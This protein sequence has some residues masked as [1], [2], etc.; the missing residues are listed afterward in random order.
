MRRVLLMALVIFSGC[1]SQVQPS[2]F[3][4]SNAVMKEG[5][6]FKHEYFLPGAVLGSYSSVKIEPV[7]LH[8][9]EDASKHDP[10]DLTELSGTFARLFEKGL[11]QA[12]FN[13]LGTFEPASSGTLV[14]KPA[15]VK[16]GTP[17]RT[18][19]AIT[20][21]VIW[22]PVTSGSAAFEAKM[23]DGGTGK[24]IAEIAEQNT[25]GSGSVESL[26]LGSYTK[27]THAEAAF[28]AW[29]KRL[30]QMLKSKGM[31]P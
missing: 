11:T 13:V 6:F 10:S 16:L 3:L 5:E 12:G 9:L 25:G 15:L 14:I 2:G 7:D 23:F 28:E 17:Q 22:T 30:A 4:G 31:R 24:V 29:G 1:A 27:Y 26:T 8:Y 19:N 18:L 20:S 21:V